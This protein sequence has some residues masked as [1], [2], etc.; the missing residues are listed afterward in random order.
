MPTIEEIMKRSTIYL[1]LLAALAEK[2]AYIEAISK[3][4]DE[5][6]EDREY[7]A[8]LAAEKEKQAKEILDNG[9]KV[10][11]ELKIAIEKVVEQQGEIA[12]LEKAIKVFQD[13]AVVMRAQIK[14]LE[15]QITALKATVELLSSEIEWLR[16]RVVLTPAESHWS[17]IGIR[18]MT[19]EE[20]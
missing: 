14:H 2:D 9:D 11:A 17:A 4:R 6:Y 16:S 19:S 1:E 3:K 13:D 10:F 8:R 15:G 12:A 18:A 5:Y 20:E 7:N